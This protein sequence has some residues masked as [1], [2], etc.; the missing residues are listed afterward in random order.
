MRLLQ[1]YQ[2]TEQLQQSCSESKQ[3]MAKETEGTNTVHPSTA[4][5]FLKVK[6]NTA[7]PSFV[8]TA[9]GFGAAGIVP[10][11]LAVAKTPRSKAL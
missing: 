9:Y 10:S 7:S 4:P 11:A 3:N 6:E 1:A 8:E 5:S 2:T